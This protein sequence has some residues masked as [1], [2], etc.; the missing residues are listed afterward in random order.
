M[1]DQTIIDQLN[2]FLRTMT[3]VKYLVVYSAFSG[4]DVSVGKSFEENGGSQDQV[5]YED[6]DEDVVD[7]LKSKGLNARVGSVMNVSEDE[8]NKYDLV[9]V[10]N[11]PLFTSEANEAEMTYALIERTK[12]GGYIIGNILNLENEEG[13]QLVGMTV[14]K[15]DQ[16]QYTEEVNKQPESDRDNKM[17]VYE[18]V[19]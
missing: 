2:S 14:Y 4:T 17:W 9:H 7:V 12:V 15:N 18:K 13:L 5:L 16:G 6:I 19:K 1:Y 10:M 11:P 8:K 3:T